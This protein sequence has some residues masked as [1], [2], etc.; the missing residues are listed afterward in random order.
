[1]SYVG[2]VTKEILDAVVNEIKKKENKE[3]ITKYVIDP[4]GDELLQRFKKPIAF[5]I[6]ILSVIILLL[7]YIIIKIS[8]KN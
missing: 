8:N 5:F 7:I 2:P 6:F 4:V 3:K 1:M